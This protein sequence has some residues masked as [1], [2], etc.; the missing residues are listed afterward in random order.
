M[1]EYQHDCICIVRETNGLAINQ[2]LQ[3]LI[4][5]LYELR[6]ITSTVFMTLN[7]A[8]HSSRII[9]TDE[10]LFVCS[11]TP[12][13]NHPVHRCDWFFTWTICHSLVR[14]TTNIV[15]LSQ[16]TTAIPYIGVVAACISKVWPGVHSNV[17]WFHEGHHTYLALTLRGIV[18]NL[19]MT[20]HYF[21]CGV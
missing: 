5:Q 6:P 9:S 8:E 2:W 21:S 12:N 16:S 13:Y 11:L 19:S 20:T 17:Y 15:E 3:Q 1:P 18:T 7:A 10:W 14:G 4:I